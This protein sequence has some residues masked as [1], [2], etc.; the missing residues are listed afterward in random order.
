L[1]EGVLEYAE[2]NNLKIVPLCPFVAAYV[3][4]HPTWQRAVSLVF[5]AEDF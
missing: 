2:R 5:N 1:V 4:R 3:N